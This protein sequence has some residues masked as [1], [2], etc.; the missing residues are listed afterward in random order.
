MSATGAGSALSLPDDG[1]GYA[2]FV[3]VAILIAPV[4]AYCRK[5]PGLAG[6][7]PCDNRTTCVRLAAAVPPVM[8]AIPPF[9]FPSAVER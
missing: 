7:R 4:R 3:T 6:P 2:G 5:A 9:W 1:P 8:N